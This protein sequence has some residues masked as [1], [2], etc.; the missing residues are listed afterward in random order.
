M[1]LFNDLKQKYLYLQEEIDLAI[2]SVLKSGQY[3]L[4]EQV[5]NFEKEFAS[6]LGVKY[7][8]GVGNGSEALQIALI[9]LDI[10][11]GDEVITTPYSMAASTI[12]IRMVG[13]K[14]VFVDIDDYFHINAEKIEPKI[15]SRTKAILPVHLYGQV[16][17]IEKIK[18]MAYKHHL[19]L[20]E[21]AA[22]AH[23]AEYKNKK[24]GTFGD[25]GCFSFY[26]TK[27]LG[28][29]GDGG[30]IVTNNKKLYDK[31]LMIRNYGQ[32]NRYEHELCG[33]NSR[34]DEIQAAILSVELKYLDKFNKKRN[35][36]AKTYY[37]LLKNV[38]YIQL[39]QIRR[40][41][42]HNFHLFV[43]EAYKR[44]ELMN[45][46]CRNNIPSF[47]YYPISIP[48]QKCFAE[49]NHLSFSVAEE[50]TNKVL[51]LPMHPFL[52]IKD[53]IYISQKIIEFYEI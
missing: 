49:F 2:K 40:Y 50:K 6:Y 35:I 28:A 52:Q 51:S 47:I 13:A 3:I 46:L 36:L 5:K 9:A 41:S 31:C 39:P 10:K 32:K 24:A 25:F 11:S 14:P 19:Y 48:K 12:A 21:D 8:I 33:L 43:I 38:K 26:P 17:D 34:L 27:N 37:K 44:D 45:F 15:N 20:I 53:I 4:G 1:I 23:G 18:R 22:Q 30:A 42:T 7:C 29:F 16:V